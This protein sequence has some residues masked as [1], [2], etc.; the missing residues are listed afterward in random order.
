GLREAAGLRPLADLGPLE[1]ARGRQHGAHEVARGAVVRRQPEVLHADARLPERVDYVRPDPDVAGE[2]RGVERQDDLDPAGPR[3]RQEPIQ[4][5][6]ALHG[7]GD[8][9]V[10]VD[11][12][13]LVRPGRG[14][15]LQGVALR[16]QPVALRLIVRADA[17]IEGGADHATS[18]DSSAGA[19]GAT[20]SR[21]S[22][23]AAQ[24]S[25][26]GSCRPTSVTPSAGSSTRVSAEGGAPSTGGVRSAMTRL[27]VPCQRRYRGRILPP[28][29]Q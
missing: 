17:E 18:G 24:R 9:L 28:S 15:G 3:I 7:T 5:R 25:P 2:P 26:D 11:V 14:R 22:R 29:N 1:L 27:T 16:G 6:P 8:P 21:T 23:M 13:D 10:R 4:L 19:A 20:P 12:G